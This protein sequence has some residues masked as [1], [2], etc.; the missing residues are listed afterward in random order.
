[1]EPKQYLNAGTS[2][3]LRG[4]TVV[5]KCR[6][7]NPRGKVVMWNH[8]KARNEEHAP[9]L[10]WRDTKGNIWYDSEIRIFLENDSEL[11]THYIPGR[12]K[13]YKRIK[14]KLGK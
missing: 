6:A 7:N 3:R 11:L 8:V 4:V 10:G 14:L 12:V 5:I 13:T 2:F 1:M 9:E